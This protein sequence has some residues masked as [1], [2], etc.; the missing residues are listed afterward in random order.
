M[1]NQAHLTPHAKT[2]FS[3]IA[4]ALG[5]GSVADFVPIFVGVLSA[6]WLVIQIYNF[7]RLDRPNKLLDRE[8]K[9]LDMA[10]K[11]ARLAAIRGG[12]VDACDVEDLL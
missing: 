10:I 12:Q 7:F 6:G 1:D 11:R 2:V 3:W 5:I 8:N 9:T 4:A